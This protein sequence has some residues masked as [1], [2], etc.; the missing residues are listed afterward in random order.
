MEMVWE[1]KGIGSSTVGSWYQ[2]TGEEIS[3]RSVGA[4]STEM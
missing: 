1:P 2:R 4:C 3:Y